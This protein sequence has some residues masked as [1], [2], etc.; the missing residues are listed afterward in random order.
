MVRVKRGDAYSTPSYLCLVSRGG[1][2]VLV[3]RF[4]G[5]LR[6]FR[7]YEVCAALTLCELGRSD[8]YILYA[9]VLRDL[10]IVMQYVKRAVDRESRSGL[11]SVAQLAYYERNAGNSSVRSRLYDCSVVA[12]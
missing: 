2:V 3:A 8:G 10:G 6:R 12:I 1:R 4:A 5:S 7:Y 9:Y 11:T